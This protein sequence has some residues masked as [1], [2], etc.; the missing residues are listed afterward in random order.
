MHEIINT[1]KKVEYLASSTLY[2]ES[3]GQINKI[4]KATLKQIK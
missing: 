2:K 3:I 4:V 1:L